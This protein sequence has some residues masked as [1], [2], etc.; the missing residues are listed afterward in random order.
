MALYFCVLCAVYPQVGAWVKSWKVYK[1]LLYLQSIFCHHDRTQ[2]ANNRSMSCKSTLCL[3][4]YS[5]YG[6][7]NKFY[8]LPVVNSTSIMRNSGGTQH[9]THS[10]ITQTKQWQAS[11]QCMSNT[12][13]TR[14]CT[15]AHLMAFLL[16]PSPKCWQV[17]QIRCGG[18][19]HA[20]MQQACSPWSA[21]MPCSPSCT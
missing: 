4:V 9:T 2:T 7:L 3:Q 1:E 18:E 8:I 21:L 12:E 14:P 15:A 6:L 17:L 10:G 13:C 5:L 11:H 16:H 20:V 19:P